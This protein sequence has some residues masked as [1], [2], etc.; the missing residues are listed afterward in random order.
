VELD[1]DGA[2]FTVHGLCDVD[3]DGRQAE[4]IATDSDPDARRVTDSDVY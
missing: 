4:Y 1:S 2:H 3:G